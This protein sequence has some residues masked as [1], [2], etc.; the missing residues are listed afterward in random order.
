MMKKCLLIV[1]S[2]FAFVQTNAQ[3]VITLD[4]QSS[5]Y[6]MDAEKG[7]WTDT[8]NAQKQTLSF[9]NGMFNF[10]HIPGGTGGTDVGGGMSYWDGFTICNSGDTTDYGKE[11][12][13]DGWV[14]EQWGCMAGGGLNSALQAQ[15]GLPYLV[16]YWGF[17]Y[18]EKFEVHAC[19]VDFD[20]M[21]HQMI[22]TYICNHP[23]PYYGNIHGDG[24][25][26]AFDHEGCRFTITA[27]GMLNGEDTG[28]E[29][30]MTLAENNGGDEVQEKGWPKGLVQSRDWQW[31]DLSALGKVDGVYFTMDSSDTDAM[32]GLNTA[33]YFCLDKMQIYEYVNT[34]VPSR[35][36]GLTT[37]NITEQEITLTWN[38]SSDATK[39]IVYLNGVKKAEVTAPT[40]TFCGLSAYTSYTLKVVAVNEIGNSDA[41]QVTAKTLDT[42]PPTAPRNVKA[43]VLDSYRV[44]VSWEA[45]RDNVGVYRYT[46]YANGK[47]EASTK[48]TSYSLTG[49]NPNT[50]YLIE[51]E[52]SDISKNTSQRSS[53]TVHT[54]SLYAEG[55]V[56]GDG[57]V[58]AEDIKRLESILLNIATDDKFAADVDADGKVSVLDIVKLISI[59][60][61]TK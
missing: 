46:I 57:K 58:D 9:N 49:L 3:Q 42:T 44:A 37:S 27:H 40:Y 39:Y 15:Q 4:L 59:L 33:A 56:N 26:S 32:W 54:P 22:G 18:E 13:S 28:S 60:H 52:A 25:C 5:S 50:T 45:S 34:S 16:G 6:T 7:C 1:L 11:G 43:E 23:W 35:P 31:M 10:S 53:I 20:K 2:L 36:S 14:A 8:Y 30:T 47:K 12:N 19:K 38:P 48:N 21:P 61:S 17:F 41:A 55:D 24:F 29:V 51:I